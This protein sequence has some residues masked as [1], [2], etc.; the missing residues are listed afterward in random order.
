MLG[1]LT[2]AEAMLAGSRWPGLLYISEYFNCKAV[3]AVA[4]LGQTGPRD[5]GQGTGDRATGQVGSG[6][7][8]LERGSEGEQRWGKQHAVLSQ[9]QPQMADTWA[10]GSNPAWVVD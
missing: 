9:V 1:V 2:G 6:G 10:E 8:G 7:V 3:R 5:G 4:S